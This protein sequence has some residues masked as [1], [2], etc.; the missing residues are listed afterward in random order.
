MPVPSADLLD[1]VAAGWRAI[2][3]SHHDH[4]ERCFRIALAEAEQVGKLD[5]LADIHLGL[6]VARVRIEA[7]RL[8][9][10]AHT[11]AVFDT[12]MAFAERAESREQTMKV[13]WHRGVAAHPLLPDVT[14]RCLREGLG[15]AEE[16]GDRWQVAF[17]GTLGRIAMERYR[18]DEAEGYF[19]KAVEAAVGYGC[20]QGEMLA[21]DGL[22]RLAG[23]RGDRDGAEEYY[24]TALQ[25]SETVDDPAAHAERL[26]DLSLYA[27]G[28]GRPDEEMM[29]IVRAIRAVPE[30]R[31]NL[32]RWLRVRRLV[33]QNGMDMLVSAWRSITGDSLPLAVRLHV[34]CVYVHWWPRNPITVRGVRTA[35]RARFG[36][37]RPD[38]EMMLL[39]R[40]VHSGRTPDSREWWYDIRHLTERDGISRLAL[41]WRA[42]TG[43]RLPLA[44]RSDVRYRTA[45]W[46][47]AEAI[48]AR[49]AWTALRARRRRRR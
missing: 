46:W 9:S 48:T 15:Y 22:A 13:L 6:T 32:W 12:A 10:S 35:L 11:D 47:P 36:R 2:D 25:I 24:R 45:S 1:R 43:K 4:A 20:W 7:L 40:A 5:L 14:E 23:R 3:S 27:N 8:W 38:E 37:R 19:R 29:L 41:A 33:E 28:R 44:V 42:V 49:E 17:L 26:M 18:L 31:D 21:L 39:V 34:H 30:S 16:S